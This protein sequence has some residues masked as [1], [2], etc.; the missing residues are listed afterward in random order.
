MKTKFLVLFLVFVVVS[1]VS[2]MAGGGSESATSGSLSEFVDVNYLMMGNVPSNGQLELAEAE[3]NKIL[4]DRLNCSM[5]ISWVEWADWLTKYNLLMA[6]GENLD[7]VTSGDWLD[8]WP[9]AARGAFLALDDLIPKYAPRTW[10]EITP[11]QWDM[12]KYNDEII[13]FPEEAYTQWVNHG[14]F[15]RGDWARE[16]GIKDEGSALGPINNFD[17]LGEYF[18]YVK[19]TKPGVVPWDELFVLFSRIG[20]CFAKSPIGKQ[21][22]QS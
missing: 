14:L 16:A 11:E 4:K 10:A 22:R 12:C 19:D 15:Y 3:W 18:Q 20:T 6:T 5:S 9:N 21:Y 8:I 1:T 17:E 13:A 7:L 2:V